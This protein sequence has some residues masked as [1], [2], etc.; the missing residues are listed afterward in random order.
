MPKIKI[1]LTLWLLAC[2]AALVPGTGIRPM[3]AQETEPSSADSPPQA[4]R[5]WY[6]KC[7]VG[8]EVGPTGAQFG[9]SE[10]SDAVYASH[11]NGRDIVRKCVEAN[12]QYLVIWARDGDWAYYDSKV[13][14]KCPGL[15][16]RDV[17]REAVDEAQQHKLPIIAYCVVQQGGHFLQDHPEYQM[18]DVAGN[19]IG[20]FC[21]NS[22]YLEPMKQLLA[23]QLAYGLDGF[24]IDMLDQGFGPPYGC[25][26]EH[27]QKAFQASYNHPMPKGAT[28]DEDWDRMLS[29]SLRHQ[30]AIREGVV[31]LRAPVES[32]GNSRFQLPW[33]SAFFL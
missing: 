19:R 27:C 1:L 14:R 28:W 7:L 2:F 15:G 30:R 33:Q 5:R 16:E 12:S 24:H 8:M 32:G 21:F 13:A 31:C 26:C 3:G 23:E 22:G 6:E 9:Y 17:L 10:P 11:F 4:S 20:R 29:L 25:W 18:V